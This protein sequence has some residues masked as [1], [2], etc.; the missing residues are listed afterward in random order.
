ML[1]KNNTKIRFSPIKKK[2]QA[3]KLKIKIAVN[4][5]KTQNL[6]RRICCRGRIFCRSARMVPP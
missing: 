6:P 1:G 3:M 4:L 5:T 2:S